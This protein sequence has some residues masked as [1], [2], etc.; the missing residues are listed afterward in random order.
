MTTILGLI[1]A[2]I[3]IIVAMSLSGSPLAFADAPSLLI[4]F[5]GTFAVTAISFSAEQL[6]HAPHTL[7]RMFQGRL[8][9]PS[10]A[11]ATMLK[12]S[13][14]ARKDGLF[15]LEQ[16]SRGLSNDVFLHRAMRLTADG[17]Q[18]EDIEKILKGETWAISTMQMNAINI[19]RRAA[20]VAPAMGLIGTLVGLVQMLGSLDDPSKIGPAMAIALLTT[21]Y[22]AILAHMVFLPLAARAEHVAREEA[23]LHSVYTIGAAAIGRKDNPRRVETLINTILPPQKR[24]QYYS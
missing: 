19:L 16:T 1:G 11:A 4:V 8:A 6:R 12:L 21:F 17:V 24:I 14:R 15:E 20:D 2:F 13:E 9:D 18:A 3:V 5:G 10:K 22:G 23:L 7:W